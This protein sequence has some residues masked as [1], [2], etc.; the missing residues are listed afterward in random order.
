M[1]KLTWRNTLLPAF[2]FVM[3]APTHAAPITT[4]KQFFGFNPGDDY[5]L[6]NYKQL[7]AYWA[8]LERESE[9]FKVVSIGKTEEG[10][11]QLMGIV[12][13]PVNHKKLAHYQTIARKL[14]LAEGTSQT[15]AHKLA[16]DGKA[17]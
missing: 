5:C 7:T 6:A 3:A 8:K 12:T 14:A 10:R 1:M 15:E 11:E 16:L 4:P 2:L 13:S 9:R 17:V